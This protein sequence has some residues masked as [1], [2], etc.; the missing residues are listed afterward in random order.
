VALS[1]MTQLPRPIPDAKVKD[2]PK[3][4]IWN[5]FLGQPAWLKIAAGI[6]LGLLVLVPIL[7]FAFRGKPT[8]LSFTAMSIS[9]MSILA[10]V[11]RGGSRR[12]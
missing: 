6:G 5:W 7:Y 4:S 3:W 1:C 9:V 11:F 8:V 2:V 12:F 10:F